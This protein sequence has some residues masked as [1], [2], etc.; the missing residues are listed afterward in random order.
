[1]NGHVYKYLGK[2]LFEK[3][4]EGLKQIYVLFT[5]FLEKELF[6]KQTMY[7]NVHSYA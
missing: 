4:L 6:T 2:L 1:M 7:K 5:H 3:R